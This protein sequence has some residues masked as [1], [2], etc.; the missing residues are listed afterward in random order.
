MDETL[1]MGEII[2]GPGNS[3]S[4]HCTRVHSSLSQSQMSNCYDFLVDDSL[5]GSTVFFYDG[6]CSKWE[7]SP[8]P[9]NCAMRTLQ[10]STEPCIWVMTQAANRRASANHLMRILPCLQ[11]QEVDV[12][13][14]N[15]TTKR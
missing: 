6:L 10:N 15:P 2:V 4:A 7:R 13:R 5:S 9:G 12:H 11:R 1:E 8:A 14:G 3:P